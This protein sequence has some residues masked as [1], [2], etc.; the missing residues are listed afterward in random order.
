MKRV[1]GVLIA[2]KSHER[3]YW[4]KNGKERKEKEEEKKEE[5]EQKEDEQVEELQPESRGGNFLT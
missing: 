5:Q 1:W 4:K 2:I 3:E